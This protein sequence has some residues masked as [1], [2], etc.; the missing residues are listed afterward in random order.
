[1]Q[2]YN[3]IHQDINRVPNY[4]CTEDFFIKKIR[5]IVIYMACK[6]KNLA[7]QSELRSFISHEYYVPLD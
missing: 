2:A 1:M 4:P 3:I 6:A 7:Q 5:R